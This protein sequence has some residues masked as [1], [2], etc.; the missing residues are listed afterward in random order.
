[1]NNRAVE[2]AVNFKMLRHLQAGVVALEWRLA[3]PALNS[4]EDHSS[5]RLGRDALAGLVNA[6]ASS[7]GINFQIRLPERLVAQPPV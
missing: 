5:G 4:A 2:R 6:R 3:E 1:L 7:G